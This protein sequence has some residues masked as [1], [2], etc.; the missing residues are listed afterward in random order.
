M[1]VMLPETSIDKQ[2]NDRVL[3]LSFWA[4]N[5]GLALMILLS[6][7]PVG[8]MQTWESVEHGMWYARSAEF[9]GKPILETLRWLRVIGDTIFAAGILGVGWFIVGLTTGWSVSGLRADAT[10]ALKPNAGG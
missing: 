9:L 10:Q 6:L 4:M 2:W 5:I 7:L 3:G 8:L 1:P